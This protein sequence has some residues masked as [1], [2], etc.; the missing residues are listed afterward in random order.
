MNTCE[1]YRDSI[2][3]YRGTGQITYDSSTVYFDGIQ[4]KGP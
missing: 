1:L 2:I 3:D 4:C